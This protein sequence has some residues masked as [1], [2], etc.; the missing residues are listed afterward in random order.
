MYLWSREE[1]GREWIAL[2]VREGLTA[3]QIAARAQVSV[4]T[5][6]R[7]NRLCHQEA[8]ERPE[9]MDSGRTF[10]QL[11]ENTT[12]NANRI[13]VV[14]PNNRRI[15]IDGATIVEALVRVLTSVKSC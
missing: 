2:G 5:V 1:R 6:H 10:V 12:A 8:L 7:W 11:I 4:R 14:L 13:E 15:L 3:K 9:V